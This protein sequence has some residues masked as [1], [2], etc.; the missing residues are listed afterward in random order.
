MALLVNLQS[1]GLTIEISN[2]MV[3][4]VNLQSHGPTWIKHPPDADL[5]LQQKSAVKR[6][7]IHCK[8]NFRSLQYVKT[9]LTL[10]EC[11]QVH[12]SNT[13]KNKLPKTVVAITMPNK[14]H[15]FEF[16]CL[17]KLH[18]VFSWCTSAALGAATEAAAAAATSI[19]TC[20]RIQTTVSVQTT[21][22]SMTDHI[23]W[24]IHNTTV[25]LRCRYACQ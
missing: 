20:T 25:W 14:Q 9:V 1:H 2:L 22:L 8:T 7:R 10:F 6:S 11:K 16:S 21:Y 19:I 18:A 23:P 12:S 24:S 15:C 3:L 13:N 17:I 5:H 4:I